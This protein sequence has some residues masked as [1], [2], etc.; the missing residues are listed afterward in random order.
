MSP[1]QVAVTGP[2]T[3]DGH[4]GP[5]Y[6]ERCAH[7]HDNGTETVLTGPENWQARLEDIL[8]EVSL[9]R[10]PIGGAQLTDGEIAMIEAWADG[11]FP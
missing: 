9:G 11:G 5:L 1:V 8:T 7:C 3:W 4:I 10:M 6:D 2:I